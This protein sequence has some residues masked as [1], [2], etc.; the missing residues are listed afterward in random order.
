MSAQQA[1]I[2]PHTA[3]NGKQLVSTLVHRSTKVTSHIAQE[4]GTGG[5]TPFCLLYSFESSHRRPQAEV[6]VVV[7]TS[8]ATIV[9]NAVCKCKMQNNGACKK[10]SSIANHQQEIVTSLL[11]VSC[12]QMANLPAVNL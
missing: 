7:I 1:H 6:P 4:N 11:T 10:G 9:F 5:P 3:T 8:D 2:H 12:I